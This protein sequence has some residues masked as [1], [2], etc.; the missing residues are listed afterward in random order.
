M[1][2]KT[3]QDAADTGILDSLVRSQSIQYSELEKINRAVRKLKEENNG[4]AQE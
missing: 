1:E 3:K 2:D 4:D